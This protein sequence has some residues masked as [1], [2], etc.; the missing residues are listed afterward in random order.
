[1]SYYNLVKFIQIQFIITAAVNYQIILHIILH[2]YL[3]VLWVEPYDIPY[4]Y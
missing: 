1:M 4:L 3:S 2:Y